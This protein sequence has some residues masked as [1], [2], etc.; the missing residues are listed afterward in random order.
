MPEIIQIKKESRSIEY[1]RIIN[2]SILFAL[3]FVMIYFTQDLVCAIFGIIY[4]RDPLFYYFDLKFTNKIVFDKYSVIINYFS[5]PAACLFIG[6]FSLKIYDIIKRN[7]NLFKLFFLWT[8][9]NGI[10]IFLSQLA[11][12]LLFTDSHLGFVVSYFN[13]N[14]KIQIALIF[15][16]IYLLYYLGKK[17]TKSFIYLMET[18]YYLKHGSRRKDYIKQV[19]LLPWVFGSILCVIFYFPRI[20][21]FIGAILVSVGIVVVTVYNN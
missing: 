18:S 7:K 12:T 10:V 19:A 11:L 8:G 9:V 17:V 3:S 2:S 4:K 20:T 16:S 14:L 21:L 15:I 13:F 6:L 5:G 1:Y